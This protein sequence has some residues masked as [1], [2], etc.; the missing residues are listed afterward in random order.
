M[1]D[2]ALPLHDRPSRKVVLRHLAEHLFEIDLPIAQ[3]PEPPRPINP[4][5]IT[6]IDARAPTWP[7]LRILHVKRANALVIKIEKGQ[8]IHLLD[9]HVARVVENACAR[10]IAHRGEEPLEG[11][12]VVQ[13]FAGM[14]LK[15]RIHS[16]LIECIQNRQ[17]ARC[18][19]LE[20]FVNKT[21]RPLWPRIKERPRQCARER[22]MR[23][24]AQ[25]TTCLGCPTQLLHRP[26][27]L[28]L[29]VTGKLRRRKAIEQRI[30][31]GMARHQL[32]LQVRREFRH[33]ESGL[34]RNP[35]HLIAVCLAF[36]GA[37][38]IEQP[39]IP[40]RNL[41]AYIAVLCRPACHA[42]QCVVRWLVARKLRQKNCRSLN[43][44]HDSFL[45]LQCLKAVSRILPSLHC[46][47]SR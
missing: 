14:Q 42:L 6:A 15:A 11:C 45:C 2:A 36:S 8:I 23:L 4:V 17:P 31:G 7:E 22:R 37:L 5:L 10:M 16:G 38:K 44:L 39:S 19:F 41:D 40:T 29:R 32:P 25:P 9:H 13:I 12:A 35:L 28:G 24:Q 27:R 43:R 18:E 21:R 20:G 46:G 34:R 47:R 1:L 26:C 3:R 30:E 33:R